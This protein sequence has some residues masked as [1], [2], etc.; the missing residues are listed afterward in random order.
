[1]CRSRRLPAF[2]QRLDRLDR[3][4]RGQRDDEPGAPRRRG[5]A[6][7]SA[8]PSTRPAASRR[9]GR[10]PSRAR[11]RL[12]ARVGLEDPVT[13][14]RRDARPLVGDPD[15]HDPLVE[16]PVDLDRVSGGAYFT[17]FS[18]RCS[19]TWR[20]AAPVGHRVQ[21][22]RSRDPS[23]WARAAARGRRSSSSTSR[24]MSIVWR[25]GGR[26][27]TTRTDSRIESTRRSSRSIWST[28]PGA[29]RRAARDAP[30]RATIGPRGGARRRAGRC[31][32][33]PRRAA[34]AARG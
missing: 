11:S 34:C 12:V 26:S 5:L 14:L 22:P 27:G 2:P 31:R 18:S 24:P 21:L 28:C 4:G 8:R 17:A 1:M 9:T 6:P 20:S 3:H 13:P 19:S 32:R 29:T 10:C 23:R 15:P 7:Q 16:S 25:S 30:G 33:G